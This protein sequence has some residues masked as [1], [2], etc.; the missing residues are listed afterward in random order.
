MQR[1]LHSAEAI[2]LS[3]W[4]DHVAFNKHVVVVVGRAIAKRKNKLLQD[5]FRAWWGQ[6]HSKMQRKQQH[7][8]AISSAKHHRLCL[9]FDNWCDLVGS[10]IPQNVLLALA[11]N[12]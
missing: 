3:H 12:Y 6:M 2:F 7:I 8:R 1:W 9:I 10:S 11:T 4:R 5:I